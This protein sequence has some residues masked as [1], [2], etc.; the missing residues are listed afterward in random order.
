MAA[1]LAA[2]GYVVALVHHLDGSSSKTPRADGPALYYDHPDWSNYKAEFRTVQIEQREALPCS[3][4][5]L[6]HC[7]LMRTSFRLAHCLLMR[8]S[9]RL[10]HCLLM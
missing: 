5:R 7:L 8:T 10:T 1:S 6:A 2:Q 9:F 4:F 3:S